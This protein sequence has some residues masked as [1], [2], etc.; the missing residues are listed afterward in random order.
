MVSY[1]IKYEVMEDFVLGTN[2]FL[3][4]F[5]GLIFANVSICSDKLV[6]LSRTC[7]QCVELSSI[8]QILC[9]ATGLQ[10]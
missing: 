1:W 4:F 10:Q 7:C 9:Q 5:T 3:H 6:E 2:P 8:I